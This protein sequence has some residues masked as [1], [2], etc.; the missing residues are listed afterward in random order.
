[1]VSLR[2]ELPL[3]SNL[4]DWKRQQL[5]NAKTELL[6]MHSRWVETNGAEG[7]QLNMGGAD[8]RKV[9]V[10]GAIMDQ[11]NLGE[12]RLWR[13]S[14]AGADLRGVSTHKARPGRP[15]RR[16][17]EKSRAT[18]TDPDVELRYPYPKPT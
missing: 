11:A 13:A 1:V 9:I 15:P 4:A 17:R 16:W 7:M 12:V 14:L 2:W 3:R 10:H 8:L 6:Q 5:E 18:L